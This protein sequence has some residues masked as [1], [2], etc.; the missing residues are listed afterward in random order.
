MRYDTRIFCCIFA[1]C[2]KIIQKSS[3]AEVYRNQYTLYRNQYTLYR[4]QYTLVFQYTLS[5]FADLFTF[6]FAHCFSPVCHFP[7]PASSS[8]F[9][10]LFRLPCTIYHARQSGMLGSLSGPVLSVSRGE[11]KGSL[12][13]SRQARLCQPLPGPF[14]QCLNY[15]KTISH[16]P[17]QFASQVEVETPRKTNLENPTVWTD[18][19]GGEAYIN[20]RGK[21]PG[22][23][24]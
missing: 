6:P 20:D 3:I 1:T 4:N 2:I 5:T 16:L 24:L 7:F 15:L 11:R 17:F 18:T 22:S 10:R 9:E 14:D 8:R 13:T 12:Q 23:E 21:E 19:R